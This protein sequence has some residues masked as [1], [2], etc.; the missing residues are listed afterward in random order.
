MR[1]GKILWEFF[2]GYLREIL[3]FGG[4]GWEKGFRGSWYVLVSV[5]LLYY[6]RKVG[7]D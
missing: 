3:R 7:E 1:D 4:V 2:C 6:R 5:I